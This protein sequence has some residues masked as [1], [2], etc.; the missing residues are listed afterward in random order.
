MWLGTRLAGSRDLRTGDGTGII[1]G[2]IAGSLLGTAI[3]NL[4]DT[5]DFASIVEYAT[6]LAGSALGLAVSN[7]SA[8]GKLYGNLDLN[9]NPAAP[10][11]ASS[12]G[13]PL[14]CVSVRYRF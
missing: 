14:P 9:I 12:V 1:L 13:A 4:Y 3:N 7:P 10:F 5:G 2:S 6:S 8:E 11:L